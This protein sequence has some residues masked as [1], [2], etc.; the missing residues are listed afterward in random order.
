MT[1]D[2]FALLVRGVVLVVEDSRQRV[3]KYRQ[4]FV[5]RYPMLGD[6][7]RCFFRFPFELQRDPSPVRY[8]RPSQVY[9]RFFHSCVHQE[10]VL[11]ED[12]HD[13]CILSHH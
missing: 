1:D 10:T 5:E 9:L 4:R 11:P 8:H 6:V 2:D 13:S 7:R 12:L 3:G